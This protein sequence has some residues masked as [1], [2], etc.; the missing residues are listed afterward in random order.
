M[1]VPGVCTVIYD[2][3]Q[4]P[5]HIWPVVLGLC[6][7]LPLVIVATRIRRLSL[8]Q[9]V[10]ILVLALLWN[11]VSMTNV[12]HHL[13]LR[14]ALA[15]GEFS[16]TEGPITEYHALGERTHGLERFTVNNHSFG[17]IDGGFGPG[18]KRTR[19]TGGQLYMGSYVRVFYIGDT[20]VHLELCPPI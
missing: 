18:F 4:E 9:R 6:L 17:F 19:R 15:R 11:I 1:N 16:R 8:I 12:W 7:L 3:A 2:V 13:Q 20:I 10:A 14:A 5:I